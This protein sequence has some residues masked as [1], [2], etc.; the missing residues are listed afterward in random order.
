M[1]I[2]RREV[3]MPVTFRT[4]RL[5]LRPVESSDLPVTAPIWASPQAGRYLGGP[6]PP[7]RRTS[8]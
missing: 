6:V 8:R 4:I 7:V 2:A 1:T 5:T 3:P